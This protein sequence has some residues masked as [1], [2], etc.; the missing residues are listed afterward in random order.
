VGT[1]LYRETRDIIL[2][3]QRLGHKSIL[4]TMVYINLIA[5]ESEDG[6]TCRVART[7]DEATKLVESGFEFVTDMDGTKIFRKRK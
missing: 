7:I 1:K 3:Q 6:W 4:N 5:G 2:V